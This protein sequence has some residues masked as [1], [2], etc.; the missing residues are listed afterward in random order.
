M[1]KPPREINTV[2]VTDRMVKDNLQALRSL[3]KQIEEQQKRI[4][5][6]ESE[7]LSK[8]TAALLIAKDARYFKIL[9]KFRAAD[10][11]K[12]EQEKHIHEQQIANLSNKLLSVESDLDD[13]E[14]DSEYWKKEYDKLLHRRAGRVRAE[15]APVGF[16]SRLRRF[17]GF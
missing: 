16:F 11:Q 2:C 9:A 17:L 7:V 6:L 14:A 4:E 8:H 3:K 15:Q 5:Y 1:P 10:R 12:L 13:A